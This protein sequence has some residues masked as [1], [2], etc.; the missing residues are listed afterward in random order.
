MEKIIKHIKK[1]IDYYQRDIAPF[2][3]VRKFKLLSTTFSVN[4]GELSPKLSVKRHV[5]EKKYSGFIENMYA[6]GIEREKETWKSKFGIENLSIEN[7]SLYKIKE[8]INLET[9]K[10]QKAIYDQLNK[11]EDK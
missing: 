4:G 1:E 3:K 6:Q 10:F 5:V 8:K 7:L 11:K 2:E 9:G